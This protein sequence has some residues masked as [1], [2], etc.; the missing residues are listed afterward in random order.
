MVKI[1]LKRESFLIYIT[2]PNFPRQ[3]LR[4]NLKLKTMEK[5][6]NKGTT[7]KQVSQQYEFF[8]D[9]HVSDI[10]CDEEKFIKLIDKT[11]TINP[12]C[13]SV[14]TFLDRMKEAL[15]YENYEAENIRTECSTS[16]GG[17]KNILTK[18]LDFYSKPVISFFK[19]YDIEVT[20]RVEKNFIDQ[21]EFHEGVILALTCLD[22]SAK[23]KK[24]CCENILRRDN[25]NHS[26]LQILTKQFGYDLKSLFKF[27]YGYLIPFENLD[28][29]ESIEL[30]HDYFQMASKIGRNVKKYPKYLRSMHDIITSNFKAYETHYNES[31]FKRLLKPELEFEN[32][33]FVIVNPKTTKD[34]ISEGTSLNHCVGSYVDK[35]LNEETYIFFLRKTEMKDLSL[36]TLELNGK[37]ITQAKGSY[38]R[39]ITKEERDFLEKYCKEKELKLNVNGG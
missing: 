24:D 31:K 4:Y 29:G 15:V 32:K 11:K 37:I 21:Y 34:I 33:E 27:I 1:T 3:K 36:V 22:L 20:E 25:W 19:K 39:V 26:Q 5:S 18:P 28:Y 13:Y 9:V 2:N 23:D 38:N 16:Y 7:W 35:I 6:Y 14:S 8:K 30:L 10:V 12:N 17:R